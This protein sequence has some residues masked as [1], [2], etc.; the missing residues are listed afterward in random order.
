VSD[1]RPRITYAEAGVDI[2]AADAAKHRIARLVRSTYTD[3]VVGDFGA[4]GG[5]FRVNAGTDDAILVASADGVGTKIKVAVMADVHDTVG[6]DLVAH[7]ADDILATGALPLFFLDYLALSRMEPDVVEQLVDGVARA[8][9]DVG[10]AL[11]GGE[12]AE[13]SDMYA[14][15]EYDLAGFIV[16]QAVRPEPVDGSKIRPG[17]RLIGLASNGLHTNGYTLVRKI[18]FDIA[19]LSVRDEMPGCGNTVGEELLR[20]HR[21]YVAA[22]RPALERGD[23]LGLAHITGGG[24][25]GNLPRMLPDGCGAGIDRGAWTVP[26]VFTTLQELGG[27][28]EADMWRTFNMGIGMIA[29]VRPDRVAELTAEWRAAGEEVFELG[30]VIAGDGVDLGRS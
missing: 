14:E 13:M 28:P 2:D 18:L 30:E 21:S 25:G 23:L 26:P 8:C 15:G 1:E 16:G 9:R 6:Y 27:V 24:I 29:A 3:G 20:T 22:L 19:A 17:D 7:C 5:C 4:F 10:C 12:T 11:L